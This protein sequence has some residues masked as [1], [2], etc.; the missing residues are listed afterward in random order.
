MF[1]SQ[2]L[3][4]LSPFLENWNLHSVSDFSVGILNFG[5]LEQVTAAIKE[6][7]FSCICITHSYLETC[8]MANTVD[9]NQMPHN[10]ASDQGLYTVC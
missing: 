10:V 3:R 2:L 9:P 7:M 5:K 8:R 1:F 4:N 6:G